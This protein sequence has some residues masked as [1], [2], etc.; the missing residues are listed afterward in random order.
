[1]LEPVATVLTVTALDVAVF[2]GTLR[3]IEENTP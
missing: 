3:A 1:M 2:D